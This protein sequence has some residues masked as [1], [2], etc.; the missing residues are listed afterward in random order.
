MSAEGPLVS[1]T[2]KAVGD[3]LDEL[4]CGSPAAPGLLEDVQEARIRSAKVL[5]A[6]VRRRSITDPTYIAEDGP[7]LPHDR[8]PL[9]E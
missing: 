1:K 3:G 2:R 5:H 4:Q 9:L 8:N 7:D 6:S